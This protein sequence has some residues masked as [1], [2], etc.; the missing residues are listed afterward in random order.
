MKQQKDYIELLSNELKLL[1]NSVAT[2]VASCEKCKKIGLKKDY[3]FEELESFD[4][5][6]SK[7]ART[8][9]IFT[10]KILRTIF[11]IL[12]ENTITFIDKVNL[13]EKLCLITS[14]DDLIEIRDLRNLIAHEYIPENIIGLFQ[15]I[16]NLSESLLKSIE[17][18]KTYCLSFFSE[19]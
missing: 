1:E 12:R 17:M 16:F 8:S 18:T 10:Q 3:N 9:D 5:L 4:S 15:D 6:T 14:A 13:A 19:K 2:F 7:F 11:F